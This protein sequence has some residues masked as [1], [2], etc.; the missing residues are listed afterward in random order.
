[1]TQTSRQTWK[2][3]SV[4]FLSISAVVV[5]LSLVLE[6]AAETNNPPVLSQPVLLTNGVVQFLIFNGRAGQ[7]NIVEVSTNLVT[8]TPVNTNVFPPTLCPICPLIVFQDTVT[9]STQR[10]YRT[11][12]P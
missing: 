2:K 6:A 10:F 8:W 1:M 5:L 3:V 11:R 7:T 4:G 9:N 12:D